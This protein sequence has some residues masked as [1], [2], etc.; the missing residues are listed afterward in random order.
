MM[1][2]IVDEAIAHNITVIVYSNVQ[3]VMHIDSMLLFWVKN[4]KAILNLPQSA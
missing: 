4:N 3:I 1:G 2:N